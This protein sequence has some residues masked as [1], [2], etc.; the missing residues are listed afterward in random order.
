M[1][2]LWWLFI[3]RPPN[4]FSPQDGLLIPLPSVQE[5]SR[6]WEATLG[7]VTWLPEEG[8]KNCIAVR[9]A[10]M[11]KMQAMTHSSRLSHR[12]KK[13]QEN[14]LSPVSWQKTTVYV[15]TLRPQQM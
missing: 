6:H 12:D 14:Q 1:S 11:A 5:Q 13:P 15:T 8:G 2:K 10:Y 3:R 7:S 4:H 9:K